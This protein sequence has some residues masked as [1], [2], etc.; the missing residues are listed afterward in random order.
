[1]RSEAEIAEAHDLLQ[2]V[3]EQPPAGLG[4]EEYRIIA[5]SV[6]VLCW[7]LAHDHNP[8]FGEALQ[9]LKDEIV[10]QEF[11]KATVQ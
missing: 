5:L 1:M 11:A 9:G 10:R 8:L 3:L 6:N 7:I 4:D 2:A